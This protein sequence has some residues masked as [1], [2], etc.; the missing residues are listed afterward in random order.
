MAVKED[1][2]SFQLS[3]VLHCLV[4]ERVQDTLGLEAQ[5]VLDLQAKTDS[6]NG[7]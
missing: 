3:T 1:T 4:P 6:V 7:P 5:Q 2:A